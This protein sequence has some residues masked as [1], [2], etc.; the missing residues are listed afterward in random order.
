LAHQPAI[1]QA[2]EVVEVYAAGEAQGVADLVGGHAHEVDGVGRDPVGRVEV[3]VEV[4]AEGDL[5]VDRA[6]RHA[7]TERLGV[8]RVDGERDVVEAAVVVEDEL[9]GVHA[10]AGH[11]IGVAR[12]DDRQA[13]QP[14]QDRVRARRQRRHVADRGEVDRARGVEDELLLDRLG[15]DLADGGAGL[16]QDVGAQL[17]EAYVELD[18]D[19]VGD[20]RRPEIRRRGE[21]LERLGS[22]I[23]PADVVQD[24]RGRAGR[25]G[26]GQDCS[27]GRHAGGV[28]LRRHR[29]PHIQ[30]LAGMNATPTPLRPPALER[31]RVAASQFLPTVELRSR[32]CVVPADG[33]A[34]PAAF[35]GANPLPPRAMVDYRSS[36]DLTALA[37]SAGTDKGTVTGLG[38]GYSLVYDLLFAGRR[39]EPLNI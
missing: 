38:H 28:E 11:R 16:A 34:A 19:R 9:A 18:G 13:A 24:D 15:G 20:L 7:E 29:V 37:N 39:L 22:H 12:R 3:E 21:A 35:R 33:A 30:R 36:M 6:R 4:R 31:L 26:R 5:P 32:G 10:R 23:D 2:D 1:G 17:A 8:G 27:H 25:R 14:R